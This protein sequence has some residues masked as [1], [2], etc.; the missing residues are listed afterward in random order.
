MKRTI[1]L[2]CIESLLGVCVLFGEASSGWCQNRSVG[3]AAPNMSAGVVG[4]RVALIKALRKLKSAYPYRQTVTT[5][6]SENDQISSAETNVIE[7]A[8]ASRMRVKDKYGKRSEMIII[9]NVNYFYFDGKWTKEVLSAADKAKLDQDPLISSLSD[10]Q[11]AGFETVKGVKCRVYT[12]RWGLD[13]SVS[14]KFP[15][16][17]GKAWIGVAD[18]LPR[19][20]DQDLEIDGHHTKSH[21][22]YEYRVRIRIVRPKTKL[23]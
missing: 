11:F 13:I 8:S 7:F 3:V 15:D 1:L 21:I 19:Q 17:I 20:M 10:V 6:Q 5:T 18:G 23:T 22:A 9:G 2:W 4:P 16:G 14:G 12:Y